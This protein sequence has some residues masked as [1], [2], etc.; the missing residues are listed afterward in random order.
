MS[1][2]TKL[3]TLCSM[4]KNKSGSSYRKS[5]NPCVLKE[6][7]PR[8]LDRINPSDISCLEASGSYTSVHFTDG[9]S[10][11]VSKCLSYCEEMVD[12]D[13][14]FRCHKSFLVNLRE[15]ED[16]SHK[17]PYKAKLR[18]GLV[19]NVAIRKKNELV[20]RLFESRV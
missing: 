8:F 17:A 6:M 1:D 18:G 13:L 3:K 7:R 20:E 10:M 19:V 15:I 5:L 9:K 2:Y 14:H 11:M 12:S 16:L 4:K